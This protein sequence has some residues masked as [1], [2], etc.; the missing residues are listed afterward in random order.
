[1][2]SRLGRARPLAALSLAA[3]LGVAL[4]VWFVI[5]AY[6]PAVPPAD[7]HILAARAVALGLAQELDRQWEDLR[8]L[9]A[10]IQ[11]LGPEPAGSE[12]RAA[13]EAAQGADPPFTWVGV[14]WA[15]DGRVA[16]GLAG[17]MEGRDLSGKA[18]F[19]AALREGLASNVHDIVLLQRAVRREPGGELLRMAEMAM[20]LR[21]GGGTATGLLMA[22]LDWQW[23][24][25]ALNAA[26]LPPGGEAALVSAEGRLMYGPDE[27]WR[28][29]LSRHPAAEV[30]QRPDAPRLG[31][32]VLVLSAAD[33]AAARQGGR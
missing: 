1:M 25:A 28:M 10:R 16:A 11:Q 33:L 30:A 32:R 6:G 5:R 17:E 13:I 26:A 31:W 2:V 14:A 27:A 15:R 18:W 23:L 3:G 19:P 21:D 29:N 4:L 12:L 7:P 8:G 22:H 9:A 20:P 24:V